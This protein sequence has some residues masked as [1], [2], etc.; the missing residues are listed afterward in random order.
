MRKSIVWKLVAMAFV[1]NAV[2]LLWIRNEMVEGV[3]ESISSSQEVGLRVVA[4]EPKER[5]E[6]ADRLLVVFNQ[7]LVE[8]KQIGQAVGWS[9][10]LIEPAAQGNW[11]WNRK[12]A[13]EFKLDEPLRK[14]NLYSCL[15]YTSPSP[16][17]RT[18]SRMPSS[19]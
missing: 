4:L 11:I 3:R 12:D 8:D 7:D 17:D 18:R 5:A 6:R 14:G 2:G 13:M 19:A 10:F 15:L 9:P 1:L 16:R